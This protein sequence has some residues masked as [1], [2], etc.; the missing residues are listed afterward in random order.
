MML[1]TKKKEILFKNKTTKLKQRMLQ[2]HVLSKGSLTQLL[3]D[4]PRTGTSVH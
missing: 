3:V 4:V 1:P 2:Y